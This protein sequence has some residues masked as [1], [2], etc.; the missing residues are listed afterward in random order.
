MAGGGQGSTRK[1]SLLTVRLHWRPELPLEGTWVPP[2]WRFSRE[3]NDR[4]TTQ[5]NV[6]H[7]GSD[8][9][10][11]SL[12]DSGQVAFLRSTVIGPG[13]LSFWW[14][15]DAQA[16]SG[17]DSFD[18]GALA[19]TVNESFAVA[20]SGKNDWKREEFRLPE[21]PNEL[22]WAA[23]GFATSQDSGAGWISDIGFE[24]TEPIRELL[25]FPSDTSSAVL[26]FSYA[27]I[28][29]YA[30]LR[31]TNLV[32]WQVW[33]DNAVVKRWTSSYSPDGGITKISNLQLVVPAS[34]DGVP[35]FFKAAAP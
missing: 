13:I 19:L 15:I 8:A 32:D 3:G 7:G 17:L 34:P 28:L 24:P 23:H 33:A 12:A 27:S 31:S 20:L 22:I 16:P 21:G 18:L 11:A 14:K 2:G 29:P 25:I 5:T 9:L 10:Q 6:V 30:I 26:D 1:A 4:W 35:A